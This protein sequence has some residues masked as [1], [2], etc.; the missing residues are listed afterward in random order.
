MSLL[1]QNPV[2]LQHLPSAQTKHV[3]AEAAAAPML[4][5]QLDHLACSPFL[6]CA[7]FAAADGVAALVLELFS[8]FLIPMRSSCTAEMS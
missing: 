3:A 4:T 2:F 6:G 7:P 1:V 8:P 5:Q